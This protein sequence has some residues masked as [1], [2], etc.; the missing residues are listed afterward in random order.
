MTMCKVVRKNNINPMMGKSNHIIV[1]LQ[2]TGSRLKGWYSKIDE[3]HP[4][5]KILKL[6]L[7]VCD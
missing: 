4:R 1:E 2:R 5:G 6:E 3:N 7:G